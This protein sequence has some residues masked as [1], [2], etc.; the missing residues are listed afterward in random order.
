MTK[1]T[2]ILI[3]EDEQ[4]TAQLIRKMLENLGYSIAGIIASGEEALANVGTIK[5]DLIIMDITLAGKIDGIE[6]ASFI[7]KNFGI[8]IVYLTANTNFEVIQRAKD[9]TNSYGYLLKPVK[10]IDLHWTINTALKRH[11]FERSE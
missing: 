6:A 2:R 1:N 5:P 4:I 11:N 3:I 9:E 8:P 7:N 10:G